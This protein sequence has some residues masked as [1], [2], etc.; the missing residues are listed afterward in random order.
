MNALFLQVMGEY[1]IQEIPGTRHNEE[2][3]KYFRLFGWSEERLSDE[4]A[5][6]SALLNWAASEV[7]AVRTGT[8]AA[9]DW[10]TVGTKVD[11]PRIGDVVI[12]W[13]ESRGSWKGHVGLYAGEDRDSIFVLGG[14]QRNGVNIR[15]YARARLLGY[16][17]LVM[18]APA[19]PEVREIII[20]KEIIVEKIVEKKKPLTDYPSGELLSAFFSV[21]FKRKKA[22]A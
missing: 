7:G 16:R 10:L 6:C 17:R 13:R 12:F 21:L 18:P 5:W 22:I 8:L 2:I 9:R 4:T 1:G 20:E 19:P 14:N 11:T 15:P 3:L